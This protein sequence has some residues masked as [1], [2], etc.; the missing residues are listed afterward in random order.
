MKAK[1]ERELSIQHRGLT[2]SSAVRT[3]LVA[4]ARNTAWSEHYARKG[5]P[6]KSASLSEKASSHSLR[7]IAIAQREA[8]AAPHGGD[9]EQA[10]PW[11]VPEGGS[12]T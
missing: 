11:F 10:P 5:D 9:G 8:D 3:E 2:L 12:N 1:R 6:M 4:W 7:E